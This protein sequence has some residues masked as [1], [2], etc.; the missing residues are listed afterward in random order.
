MRARP[1]NPT[2]IFCPTSLDGQTKPEH[3]L[4][5]SLGGKWE[6]KDAICS[7]C[8]NG[9][10]GSIDKVFSEQVAHFRNL[11]Q[12]KS[13]RK[14]PPPAVRGATLD[15]ARVDIGSDGTVRQKKKPFEITKRENGTVS[16][17]INSDSWDGIE[18]LIP[19]MA[20][21]AGV[22]EDKLREALAQ[23]EATVIH[24]RP[25][26]IKF[27]PLFGGAE[28]MR[29]AAK[30]CL[31]LWSRV[32]G[33]AEV[34]GDA[35]RE[36]RN[37]VMNGD[38]AFLQE[39]TELDGRPL[40]I[41]EQVTRDFG[42]AFNLIYVA[43]DWDGKVIGHFTVLNMTGYQIVLATS[44]GSANLSTGYLNDP[45][46]GKDNRHAEK[47]YPIPFLW[48][49][50]PEYDYA[51]VNLQK[52]VGPIMDHHQKV[53]MEREIARTIHDIFRE[54]G[55]KEGDMITPDALK[56]L[57]TRLSFH[58]VGVPYKQKIGPDEMRKKFS[59]PSKDE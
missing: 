51:A 53:G 12:I 48:L 10:G 24:R 8:N 7:D 32:V 58:F 27:S 2:C 49:A 56:M 14:A 18:S 54:Q 33:N 25:D 4:L 9:F 40:E 5:N 30:A 20:A 29:S 57:S 37:F 46:S 15:G 23:T 22:S 47:A 26:P 35:Y 11:L 36:V 34:Q 21:A 59:K 45:I 19:H 1:R 44:G 41:N 6:V 16:L 52:R 50:R 3:I 38:E 13:G 43:S 42:P 28:A 17:K 39:R 31:I 55:I